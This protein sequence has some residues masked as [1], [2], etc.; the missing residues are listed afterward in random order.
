MMASVVAASDVRI[1]SHNAVPTASVLAMAQRSPHGI[2]HSR[3]TN[4][5]AKNAIA[6]SANSWTRAGKRSRCPLERAG[7]AVTVR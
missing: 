2:R 7:R 6:T 5:S 1:E 4:G 3:P